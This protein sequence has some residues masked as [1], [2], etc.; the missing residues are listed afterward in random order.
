M[1]KTQRLADYFIGGGLT[2]D[3]KWLEGLANTIQSAPKA[4]NGAAVKTVIKRLLL[5]KAFA[6]DDPTEG[7]CYDRAG[8]REGS[9]N[10]D[11]VVSSTLEK[12]CHK[13]HGA[14]GGRGGLDLSTW[15]AKTGFA[16]VNEDDK[17]Y[18]IKLSYQ[19]ILDRLGPSE[20]GPMMPLNS[21]M[22][23]PD[24]RILI[25]WFEKQLQSIK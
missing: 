17:P 22:P 2:H 18:P 23:D 21:P 25:N 6:T 11:C 1:C 5:S 13:C 8:V 10:L 3:R 4:T 14:D 9:A 12:Y 19:K 15:S 24:R 7:V 16:H 20:S